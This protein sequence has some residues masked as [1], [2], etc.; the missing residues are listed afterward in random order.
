MPRRS[1]DI[2][3]DATAQ[4]F[5]FP[6]WRKFKSRR[7]RARQTV[8]RSLPSRPMQ[9]GQASVTA[10]GAAGHRAAHQVLERGFVFADPLALRI[11][12]SDADERH[13]ARQGTAGAA[14][15]AP[16]HRDAQPLRRGFGAPCDRKRRAADPGSGRRSRHLRLSARADPGTARSS[17]SIIRRRKPRSDAG[18]LRRK[19][20]SLRMSR[21]SLTIS[22][23]AA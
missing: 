10:L 4:V 16:V 18:S 19:S 14:R 7:R 6:P 2:S 17:S 11:L 12:G 21:T 8:L 15:L 3:F 9:Q 22:K 23:A 20:P 5:R 1:H 13:R